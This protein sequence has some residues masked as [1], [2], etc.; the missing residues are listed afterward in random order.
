[1]SRYGDRVSVRAGLARLG[2]PVGKT[3]RQFQDALGKP[4]A[5]STMAGGLRLLQWQSGTFSRQ[6]IAVV[7]TAQ[8]VFIR[9]ASRYHV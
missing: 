5:I 9:I 2:D 6:S 7:F 3:E 4:Q 1:M 8:H